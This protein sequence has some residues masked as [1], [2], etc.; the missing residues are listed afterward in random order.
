MFK[1]GDRVRCIYILGDDRVKLGEVYEVV[2]ADIDGLIE[3]K[4]IQCY[5]N[6]KRF[7][8]VTRADNSAIPP[9]IQKLID[10]KMK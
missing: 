8:L 4:G 7:E 5:Y 10:S 2:D 3:V 9:Q 6:G 1:V